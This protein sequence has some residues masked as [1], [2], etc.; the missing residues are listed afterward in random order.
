M[1]KSSLLF[2]S[3][4]LANFSFGQIFIDNFKDSIRYYHTRE[5]KS[6]LVGFDNRTTFLKGK[7]VGINGL[8]IGISHKKFAY[9]LGFYGTR[10]D[11]LK[12]RLVYLNPNRP[13]TFRQ[14]IGFGYMSFGF[15]YNTWVHKHFFLEYSGQIGL[16]N[17]TIT[18]YEN[19]VF[20][21]KAG[22]FIAP[23]ELSGKVYYMFTPWLGVGGGMGMRKA[24]FS[25]TNF[26]GI[27]YTAGVRFLIGKFYKTVIKK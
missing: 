14:F 25:N 15:S 2:F 4:L 22:T 20:I 23:L 10:K 24:L 27:F 11:I 5:K 26:D 21:G 17:G 9:F 6:L 18:T 12:E 13:D 3:F 16:G 19:S 8:K 7:L 1:L